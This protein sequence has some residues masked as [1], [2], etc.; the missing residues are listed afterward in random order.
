MKRILAKIALVAVAATVP[1]MASAE[2]ALEGRWANP[3]RSV[4]VN[5]S[6]CGDGY[7][8]TVGWVNAKNREKGVTAGTRVLS[9]LKPQGHGVYKGK[10][11]EPKRG[12]GGSAT[13]RQ[14]APNVMVVK[15]CA[16]AGLFCKSQRWTRVS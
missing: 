11:Y 8:G 6:R 15:G 10:A 9:D 5:V 16:I 2:A 14:V 13:V 4:I 3:H 1:V 12:I 7:C